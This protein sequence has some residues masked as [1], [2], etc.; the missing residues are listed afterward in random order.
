MIQHLEGDCRQVLPTLPERCVH[1]VVT[2]P[3]YWNQRNYLGEAAPDKTREIGQEQTPQEYVKNLIQVFR[4]VHRVLRDD[5]TLWLN[6]GDTYLDRRLPDSCLKPKDLIGLPWRVAFNLIAEGW[7]LRSDIIWHKPDARPEGTVADR[8]TKSHEYLFLLSKCAQYYYDVD[9]IRDPVTSSGGACFGKQRHDATGTKAQQRRLKSPEE[10]NHP[11]GKNKRSVWTVATAN[12]HGAH[13]AVFP[14]KLIRPC[15]LAGCPTGGTVLD[16]F[17]GSGTV[18]VVAE[19]L[20]CNSILIDL[21]P[22]YIEMQK[23][24]TA[25]KSLFTQPSDTQLD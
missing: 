7:Y 16:P 10:R 20:G 23:Q 19:E 24:R 5:G 15:I 9:A 3:P 8:P 21:N 2:S 6:L 13:F 11:K 14:E 1:C 22:V 25:M 17:A 12:F 4:A 18:G